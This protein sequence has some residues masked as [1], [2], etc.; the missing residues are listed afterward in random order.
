MSSRS[1]GSN[2][3]S[4]LSGGVAGRVSANSPKAAA[5][6]AASQ[7]GCAD[8]GSRV[9]E[10]RLPTTTQP[11][12]PNMRMCEYPAPPLGWCRWTI[13]FDSV[14]DSCRKKEYVSSSANS[15][16]NVTRTASACS[17]PAAA[18]MTA[19]RA[20]HQPAASANS[21]AEANAP[22]VTTRSARNQRSASGPMATGAT[23]PAT[24]KVV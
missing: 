16:K 8:I 23:M 1:A 6:P 24:A 2:F 15:T 17:A 4:R 13:T 18:A 19:A 14:S 22:T 21:S 9:S 20:S 5:L 12:V 10:S 11:M 7:N 3:V